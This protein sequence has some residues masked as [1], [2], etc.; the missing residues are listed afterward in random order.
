MFK[1]TFLFIVLL[2]EKTNAA[3]G[4]GGMPQLNPDSFTSQVFWLLVFF[5]SLFLINHYFFLPKLK[6][7]REERDNTIEKFTKE[8]NEI[9]LS[10]GNLNDKMKADLEEAK[11]RKNS[12]IKQSFEANK[13]ILDQ[14]IFEINAEFE[15]KKLNLNSGIES[16]RKKIISSIPSICVSLSDILY[17]KIMGE[18]KKGNTTEFNKLIGNSSK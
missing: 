6:R 11:I 8:A 14:K 7:I 9:N 3:E 16:S 5:V 13:R 4:K 15:E 10:I 17:E 18:K 12:S 2:F 1:Y